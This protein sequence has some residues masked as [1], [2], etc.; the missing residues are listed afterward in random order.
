[1]T[2]IKVLT[3]AGLADGAADELFTAALVRVLENIQDPNTDWKP[4]R[5]ITLD[6]IFGVD[7]QRQLGEV[8]L[9]CTTKLAGIRGVKTLVS[10]GRSGG[11]DC[12][13]E[14]P[15]TMDMF[16]AQGRPALVKG[17]SA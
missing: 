12:A 5:H 13:V 3:L 1:M 9:R 2:D 10:Y 8:E 11:R 4:R 16:D 6:V 15:R 7:E 14:H 17:A